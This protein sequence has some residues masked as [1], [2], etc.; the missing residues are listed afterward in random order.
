MFFQE[1]AIEGRQKNKVTIKKKQFYSCINN[2][3]LF[4]VYNIRTERRNKHYVCVQCIPT[5]YKRNRLWQ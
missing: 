4:C 2:T 1:Q 5:K 3:V